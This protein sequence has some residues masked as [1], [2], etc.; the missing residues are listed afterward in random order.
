MAGVDLLFQLFALLL[1]LSIAELLRGLGRSCRI[2]TGATKTKTHVRIGW[3]V[4][5]LGLLLLF[6]QTH[7]WVSAYGLRTH[8]TFNYRTL[9]LIL[10]IIGSYYILSTF[11]FPDDP[12]DWADFD[13][14]YL[15]TNRIVIGGMFA[16]NFATLV[17]LGWQI[18]R[19]LDPSKLPF[20]QHW[21][22][23]AAVF[24]YFPGLAALWLV[25]SPR[26][27]LVLLLLMILL[28]LIGA[29]GPTL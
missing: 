29:V 5:L 13:D 10:T 21:T 28:L 23:L 14:Y 8:L 16:V 20:A 3:L 19:G 4:P 6:D 7:F 22:S 12:A 18:E 24:L 9:L 15:T 17:N 26:A 11:V 27:N 1:G 25:K 2:S